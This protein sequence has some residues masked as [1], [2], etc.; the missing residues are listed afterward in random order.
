MAKEK[1]KERDNRIHDE[2]IV[3]AYGEYEQAMSWYY[4]MEENLAF[5]IKAKVQL[6]LQGGKTEEKAVKLLKLTLKARLLSRCVWALRKVK[7]NVCNT[8]APPI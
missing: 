3:D 1:D 7:V 5:P 6:R 4:H 2:I 8:S